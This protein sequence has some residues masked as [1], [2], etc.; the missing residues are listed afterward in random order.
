M[1]AEHVH[2]EHPDQPMRLELLDV[3]KTKGYVDRK[4]RESIIVQTQPCDINRRI[5]GNGTVGNIYW[6]EVEREEPPQA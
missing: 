1:L 5:E 2:E 3:I 6:R 4:N